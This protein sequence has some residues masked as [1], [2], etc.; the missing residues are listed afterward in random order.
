MLTITHNL[1]FLTL[2][3]QHFGI[4]QYPDSSLSNHVL[5]D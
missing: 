5:T 1:A 2:Q 3:L 4:I